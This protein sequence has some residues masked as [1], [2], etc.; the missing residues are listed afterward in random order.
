MSEKPAVLTEAPAQTPEADTPSSLHSDSAEDQSIISRTWGYLL[1]DV[2]P[3]GFV[4][5]ELVLLT[6]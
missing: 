3:S 6:L 4:E 2:R 5:F 1:E